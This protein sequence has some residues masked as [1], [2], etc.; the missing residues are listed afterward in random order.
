MSG[1]IG[2]EGGDCLCQKAKWTTANL[3]QT[4]HVLTYKPGTFRTSERDAS[5][6]LPT[7]S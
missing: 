2:R 1:L 7:S 3:G 6:A 5:F 4:R